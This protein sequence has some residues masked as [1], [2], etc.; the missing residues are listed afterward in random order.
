MSAVIDYILAMREI[1]DALRAADYRWS[2]GSW[3]GPLDKLPACV[4]ALEG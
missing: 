4:V 3:I 2:T 1:L